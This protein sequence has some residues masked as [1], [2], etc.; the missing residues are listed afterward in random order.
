MKKILVWKESLRA[1]TGGAVV[2]LLRSLLGLVLIG[3]K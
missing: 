1:G 2:V 3:T